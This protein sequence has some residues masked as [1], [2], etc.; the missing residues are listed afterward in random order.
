MN[1]TE[2]EVSLAEHITKTEFQA[3]MDHYILE[4]LKKNPKGLSVFGLQKKL[5]EENPFMEKDHNYRATIRTRLE[6][7]KALGEKNGLFEIRTNISDENDHKGKKILYSYVGKLPQGLIPT[8]YKTVGSL[9]GTNLKNLKPLK[10]FLSHMT[11]RNYIQF[12]DEEFPPA[13]QNEK[14]QENLGFITTAICQH[15]SLNIQYG[16]YGTDKKLHPRLNENGTIKIYT[17]D[18][19]KIVISMGRCYLY[20]RHKNHDN[21]SC[22]RVDR[23]ITAAVTDK[24]DEQQFRKNQMLLESTGEP[25]FALRLYMYTG[26]PC[27]I[28]LLTDEEHLNDI[29][30]WFGTN[31]IIR[32]ESDKRVKV[33]V[34][35]DKQAML[36]WAMQYSQF[37]TVIDPPEMAENIR[38]SLKQAYDRYTALPPDEKPST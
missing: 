37:V 18:P 26:R 19:I 25:H 16:D 32:K 34:H 10:N 17:V 22:L 12:F 21:L 20:C 24:I 15:Q 36:Y 9:K 1:E 29:F 28:T 13:L 31:I 33:T 8:M 30:D 38:C 23:I 27:K 3:T 2:K 6:Y 11:T 7:L 14:M 5:V 35:S 4:I